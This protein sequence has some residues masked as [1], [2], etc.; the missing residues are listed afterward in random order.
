MNITNHLSLE[1][2]FIFTDKHH[3]DT[4]HD[5]RIL[6]C[7]TKNLAMQIISLPEILSSEKKILSSN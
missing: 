3:K 4:C 5:K 2:F 1:T 7:S 6:V